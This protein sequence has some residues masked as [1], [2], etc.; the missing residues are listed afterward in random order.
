MNDYFALS[1]EGGKVYFF[2]ATG[3]VNEN[4]KIFADSAGSHMNDGEF[5]G[6]GKYF[7]TGC[8]NNGLYIFKRICLNCSFGYYED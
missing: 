4:I 1:G 5:S 2:D 7:I 3:E 6:I 8:E